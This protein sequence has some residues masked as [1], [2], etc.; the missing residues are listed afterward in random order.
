MCSIAELF[1][2]LQTKRKL[3][4]VVLF[5]QLEIG[6]IQSMELIKQVKIGQYGSKCKFKLN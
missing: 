3:P 4:I 2:F 6:M 1:K 5:T